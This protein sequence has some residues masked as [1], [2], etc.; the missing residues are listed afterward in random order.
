MPKGRNPDDLINVNIKKSGLPIYLNA[1]IMEF[2]RSFKGQHEEIT[3]LKYL[4]EGIENTNLFKH[5]HE[6]TRA[7]N[8]F[9]YKNDEMGRIL[10]HI[11]EEIRATGLD[12][13]IRNSGLLVYLKIYKTES[14]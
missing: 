5:K 8:L 12:V 6:E 9:K 4:Q 10:K 3:L 7:F 14:S 2:G 11:L 13:D 1:Y